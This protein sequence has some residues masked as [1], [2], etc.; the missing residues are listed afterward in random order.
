M[1][2]KAGNEALVRA[3][4]KA[5]E[6]C[7]LEAILGMMTPDAV[8]Q[9]LPLPAMRGHAEI[10]AFISPNLHAVQRME[11]DFLAVVSDEKSVMTERVDSFVFEEGTVA[12]PVMGIFEIED[13]LIARWRDYADI[14]SFVRDMT[15]IGRTPGPGVVA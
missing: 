2:D 10:G 7:D 9:N 12:I 4:G 5:W 14:G 15:A 11:W 6:R 13:G 8:Y 1:A 3:F